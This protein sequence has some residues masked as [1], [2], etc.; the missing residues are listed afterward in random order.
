MEH[1]YIDKVHFGV[2]HNDFDGYV[3]EERKEKCDILVMSHHTFP[4]I[5]IYDEMSGESMLLYRAVKLSGDNDQTVFTGITVDYGEQKRLSVM[6]AHKGELID[7][8]DT[9]QSFDDGEYALSKEVKIFNVKGYPIALVVD[10]DCLS[11]KIWNGVAEKARLV[12]NLG[13]HTGYAAQNA[14]K[15]QAEQYGVPLLFVSLHDSFL[16]N[17]VNT[18]DRT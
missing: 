1:F 13:R 4:D 17:P 10:M 11:D 9:T 15:K 16:Y 8:V 18:F 14:A 3:L 6:V 12:L 5:T 7:I 2:T